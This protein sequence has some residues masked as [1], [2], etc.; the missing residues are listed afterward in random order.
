M[1]SLLAGLYVERAADAAPGSSA[2]Q[3]A[4]SVLSGRHR[5]LERLTGGGI[6][7]QMRYEVGRSADVLSMLVDVV[8]DACASNGNAGGG[9]F[10]PLTNIEALALQQRCTLGKDGYDMLRVMLPEGLLPD[11]RPVRN[12][13]YKFHSR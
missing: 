13:K 8:E 4:L 9:V 3:Q 6:A 2:R 1:T 11:S 12:Q 10:R 7:E 5:E